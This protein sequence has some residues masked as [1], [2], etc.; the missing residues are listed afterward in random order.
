MPIRS[1]WTLARE[2]QYQAIAVHVQG[3]VMAIAIE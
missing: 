2:G 3:V 1:D